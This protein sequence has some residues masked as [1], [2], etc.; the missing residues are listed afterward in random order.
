VDVDEAVV[1]EIA[2][3]T[4]TVVVV[5]L[6]QAGLHRAERVAPQLQAA[7]GPLRVAATVDHPHLT[8]PD[9]LLVDRADQ[10][11]HVLDHRFVDRADQA[12]Y[13]L[14]LLFVD[15]ADQ[16][17]RALG[18]PCVAAAVELGTVPSHQV[19]IRED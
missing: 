15:R 12:H 17:H 6:L 4:A 14:G 7:Q 13:V 18:L 2:M 10:A 8:D 11:P 5:P 1:V 9:L 19:E 3:V 16:A